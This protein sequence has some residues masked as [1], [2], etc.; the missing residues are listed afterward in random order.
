MTLR[1]RQR[2]ERDLN[3]SDWVNKR[4][5]E[6]VE[7]AAKMRRRLDSGLI[8]VRRRRRG[9]TQPARAE[10]YVASHYTHVLVNPKKRRRKK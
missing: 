1:Q 2:L 10:R 7:A 5:R 3:D 6:L 4:L 8:Y 9:Y